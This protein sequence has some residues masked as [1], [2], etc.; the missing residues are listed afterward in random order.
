MPKKKER[1][2]ASRVFACFC[3][4]IYAMIRGML[5]RWQGLSNMLRIPHVN[6]AGM[7]IPA[8]ADMAFDNTSKRCVKLKACLLVLP[9][10]IFH[11]LEFCPRPL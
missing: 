6:A 2:K 11:L 10:A 9:L 5:D 7:A 3:P 1:R 8:D 4:L